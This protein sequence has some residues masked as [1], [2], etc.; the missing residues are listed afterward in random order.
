MSGLE[1]AAVALGTAVAKT[2]CEMWLGD[3]KL[4]AGIAAGAVDVASGRYASSREQRQFRRIWEQAAE[5]VADQVEPLIHHEYRDLAENEILAAIDAVRVTFNSAA[6]THEDLFAQDLDAAF[7]DRHLRRCDEERVVR[8]GLSAAGTALY[9]LL[10]RECSAYIIEMIHALPMGASS[11]AFAELLRRERQ[12]IEDVREVL[13]RLPARR[14][15]SDFERD[16]RQLVANRIDT[17]EFYGATVSESSR[18]YPL[19]VAYLNL[20]VSGEFRLESTA[21]ERVL[22]LG[23]LGPAGTATARVDDVLAASRRLFVRGQA[24]L[25]KTTLLQWI[26]VNCARRTF[27][28]QLR[29]W[30]DCV[31]FFVPLRRHAS[32]DLPAPEDFL[33]EVGRH[34]SAEKPPGWVHDQLRSGR[35]VVLIDGVD[36]LAENR[37]L[38]A[39]R[40][41]RDL[42]AA[43]PLARFVI[44][45]RPAATPAEWLGR[46]AFDVA[47][48]EPM[49]RTDI[50]VFIARWHEAMRHQSTRRDDHAELTYY[51]ERFAGSLTQQRHLRQMASYPLL[52]ALLCALHRD[53]RGDLPRSRMEIYEVALHMLLERRDSERRLDASGL[54][55]TDKTLLLRDIAYWLIRNDRS[56]APAERIRSHIATKL[57]SMTQIRST[58]DEVYRLLLERTGLLREAVEGETDFVH[59]SF[60]EYLAAAEAVATDDIGAL[61]SHAYTDFW[62]EVVVMAAGHAS[63][64]QRT[65][66]LQGLLDRSDSEQSSVTRHALRLVAVACLETSPELPPRLRQS[67]KQVTADLLPPKTMAAARLLSRTGT[68]TLD[69]LA[70]SQPKSADEAAA[71]IRAT[72]EIADP[73]GLALLARFSHDTRKVVRRELL[74][75]WRRFD[76]DEYA[77]KVLADLPLRNGYLEI[78]DPDQAPTLHRLS[79]LTSLHCS[80]RQSSVGLSF[81]SGLPRLT[82]LSTQDGSIAD[83]TPL[84]GTGLVEFDI[85]GWRSPE[86]PPRD[87]SPLPAATSLE[88]LRLWSGRVSNTAAL[89]RCQ[90]LR[91]LRLDYLDTVDA[92]AALAPLTHLELLGIGH[93][94]DLTDL[95]P[96]YFLDAP[97]HIGITGCQ[98]ADHLHQLTRWADHLRELSLR[99]FEILDL[100]QLAGLE[101]LRFLD[102]QTSQADNLATLA[103]L[104][105]L[106]TIWCTAETTNFAD[107]RKLRSLRDV[108]V[109]GNFAEGVDLSAMTDRTDLTIRVPRTAVI[110]TPKSGGPRIVRIGS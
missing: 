7:L 34:I 21:E 110:H 95:S 65:E 23:R 67:L 43:F 78:D 101:Q 75:A 57:Q 17:I 59:R 10:L 105:H 69:L 97:K 16:Y 30:N 5:L 26:A 96:L 79:N 3:H 77:Q 62:S 15:I 40:W 13:K 88:V 100:A 41:L 18:H 107:L 31:P 87:L 6:L 81:M 64:A 29:D 72:A 2:A 27:A 99:E 66:L 104:P 61:V 4:L 37:R 52:C 55:R 86:Q 109:S 68:F 54:S 35:A 80:Y 92:L 39:R 22:T 89:T 108:I 14:G 58:A 25:G 47:E 33:S 94:E 46:E 20:S 74:R 56:S 38:E 63:V 9:D 73:A 85:F 48:L 36:E 93:I 106:E 42:V 32:V 102:L 84:A 50:A 90:R 44:T 11:A 1:A 51:E 24:G 82:A 19:S 60:Q 28:K 53:R 8:A 91:K 45:S 70:Q 83:L 71:T 103:H 49:S 12:V 98:V 76:A